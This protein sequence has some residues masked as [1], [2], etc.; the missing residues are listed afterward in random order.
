MTNLAFFITYAGN[1]DDAVDIA[2]EYIA[3]SKKFLLF[4]WAE[5]FAVRAKDDNELKIV[6]EF[7][8][9]NYPSEYT[10]AE[11]SKMYKEQFENQ[12]IDM[13]LDYE[14]DTQLL[15][16][17]FDSIIKHLVLESS[18][19]DVWNMHNDTEKRKMRGTNVLMRR[20][21]YL[22]QAE[23]LA[24]MNYN[25]WHCVYADLITPLGLIN[26]A[27]WESN[28]TGDKKYLVAIEVRS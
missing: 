3:L 1:H 10:D 14:G 6:D 16:K 28:V 25:F 20:F 18:S 24:K 2:K 11:I 13:I 21:S 15:K 12:S 5:P 7:L 23:D 26:K 17:T 22:L 4:D 8:Y 27:F 19:R 9:K